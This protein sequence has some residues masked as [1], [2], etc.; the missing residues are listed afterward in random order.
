[1]LLILE[2]IKFKIN[3][4]KVDKALFYNAKRADSQ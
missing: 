4:I 3:S 1:M 2:K